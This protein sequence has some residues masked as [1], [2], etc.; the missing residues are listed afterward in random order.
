MIPFAFS[1]A[2]VVLTLMACSS[3]AVPMQYA[4][5]SGSSASF[6]CDSNSSPV[7]NRIQTSDNVQ[8]LAFGAQRMAR[9]DDQR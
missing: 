5:S 6:H 8:S 4:Q 9:F 7:W 2:F 3:K 1:L